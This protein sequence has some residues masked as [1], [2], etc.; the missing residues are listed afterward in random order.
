LNAENRPFIG[1]VLLVAKPTTIFLHSRAKNTIVGFGL[2]M[3]IIITLVLMYVQLWI[4]IL[5]V[6]MVVQTLTFF[7]YILCSMQLDY[8]DRYFHHIEVL[9]RGLLLH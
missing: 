6:L 8:L 3:F 5:S 7:D 1:G 9:L 4:T 2:A